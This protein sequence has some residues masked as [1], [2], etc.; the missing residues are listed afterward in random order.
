MPRRPVP[1][2]C[3]NL[4]HK[5]AFL[6]SVAIS[7]AFQRNIQV[8]WIRHRDDTFINNLYGVWNTSWG[9]GHK[10]LP[11]TAEVRLASKQR[12]AAETDQL[13]NRFLNAYLEKLYHKGP[14]AAEEYERKMENVRGAANEGI[15]MA[16][17]DAARINR[18]VTA[19]LRRGIIWLS[20]IK[21]TSTI[22]VAVLGALPAL[23]ASAT[24]FFVGTGYSV[25]CAWLKDPQQAKKAKVAA[26]ALELGKAAASQAGDKAAELQA[27]KALLQQRQA[28]LA[29]AEA[30]RKVR[31]YQEK[32]GKIGLL[33]SRSAKKRAAAHLNKGLSERSIAQAS[34]S[35][36]SG[37]VKMAQRAGTGVSVVFAAWDIIEALGEFR[38][39]VRGTY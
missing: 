29:L 11:G 15:D 22:T 6:R 21:A 17:G 30:S 35:A 16:F 20:G 2:I 5:V 1:A 8:E 19:E 18:G 32:L 12:I 3:Y 25:T 31:R 9:L 28:E 34:R 36:A 38:D 37:K 33:K 13:H 26:V 39:T 10:G 23:S 4:P 7:M 14:Q 27:A 24:A